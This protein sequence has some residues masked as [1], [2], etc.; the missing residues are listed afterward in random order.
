M[1]PYLCMNAHKR[2]CLFLGEAQSSFSYH[3]CA[4]HPAAT[5]A[6]TLSA[7]LWLP[8][9]LGKCAALPA[10]ASSS[11]ESETIS[12]T[13]G[14]SFRSQSDVLSCMWIIRTGGKEGYLG[15]AQPGMCR[16]R[17]HVASATLIRKRLHLTGFRW[18][19]L[20]MGVQLSHIFSYSIIREISKCT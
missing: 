2:I 9:G 20:E 13:L 17:K 18:G 8:A 15:G 7:R 19:S 11:H 12:T 14:I 5:R 16:E 1:H 3:N 10:G 4:R 6:T